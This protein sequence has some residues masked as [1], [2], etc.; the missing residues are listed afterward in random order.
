LGIA[1]LGTRSKFQIRAHD[2]AI[3]KGIEPQKMRA[4]PATVPS[5]I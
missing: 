4:L 2:F 1:I 5:T 3:K